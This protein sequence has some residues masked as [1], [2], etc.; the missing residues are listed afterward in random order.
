MTLASNAL[1]SN[2]LTVTFRR[3]ALMWWPIAWTTGK[4]RLPP[5]L[6]RAQLQDAGIPLECA[7]FGRSAD[8]SS[9]AITLLESQR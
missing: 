6:S 4:S 1:A 2:P 3:P 7:G 9:L 5:D 8:V